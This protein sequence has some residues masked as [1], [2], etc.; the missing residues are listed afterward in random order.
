MKDC[1][2]L[3]S[4]VLCFFHKIQMNKW[5]SLDI[6]WCNVSKRDFYKYFF[7]CCSNCLLDFKL[8]KRGLKEMLQKVI[9]FFC[10]FK[11]RFFCWFK[12]KKSMNILNNLPRLSCLVV[13]WFCKTE[14]WSQDD[15]HYL[16]WMA[17]VRVLAINL[18][19]IAM[20][21]IAWLVVKNTVD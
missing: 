13:I 15:N 14:W 8:V 3:W 11:D 6:F 16:Y 2:T 17:G 12:V 1:F 7:C 18:L 9:M 19:D 20:Q 21:W 5:H 10:K 4:I